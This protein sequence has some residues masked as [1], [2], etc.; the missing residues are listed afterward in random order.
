MIESDS[1]IET[2]VLVGYCVFLDPHH[3]KCKAYVDGEGRDLYT[4]EGVH[5]EYEATKKSVSSRL[6]NA[7][8]DHVHDLKNE[9]SQGYLDPM[10]VNNIKKNVL[11]HE[12][13][14]YQ[15][16]YRYY[17]DVVNNGIQKRELEGNLREIA[18][19]I[20]RLVASRQEELEEMI[21]EWEQQDD[22]PDIQEAL[23]MI[24]EPDR[25]WAVEAHDLAIH[26]GSSIE[27]A[28][29][30]PT[31]FIYRGRKQ[32]ILDNT[33]LDDVVDLSV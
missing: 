27:F 17:D 15:F 2:G 8:L 6:S 12:N 1:F 16:L 29:T 20:D 23:S 5:K 31:D 11:H 22:H 7:V 3:A 24:H 33:A 25:T 28:T 18:R 14:A 26:N 13:D 30:N 4:S 21:E 19:D 9:V 32:I 10:D